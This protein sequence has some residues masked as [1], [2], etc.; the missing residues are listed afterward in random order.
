MVFQVHPEPPPSISLL[1]NELQA[2]TL[3]TFVLLSS[4]LDVI[5]LLKYPQSLS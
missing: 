5:R 4:E 1:L 2:S 3:S